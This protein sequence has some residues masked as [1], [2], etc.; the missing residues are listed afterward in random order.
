MDE[1]LPATYR[2][3]DA[4][5]NLLIKVA[6]RRR[7]ASPDTAVGASAYSPPSP[8]EG[9]HDEGSELRVFEF[10]WQQKIYGPRYVDTQH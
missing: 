9:V 4:I 1:C 2:T 5:D 8:A 10:A 3:G 7:H 6:I